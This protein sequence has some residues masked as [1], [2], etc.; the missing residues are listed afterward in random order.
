[1]SVRCDLEIRPSAVA[2]PV[3]VFDAED[4]YNTNLGSRFRLRG[5]PNQIVQRV[6]ELQAL[7]VEHLVLA[8]NTDDPNLATESISTFAVRVAPEFA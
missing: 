2:S 1:M 4:D 7:G 8:V 3:R 5:T 6:G